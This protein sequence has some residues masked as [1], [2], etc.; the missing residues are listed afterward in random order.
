MKK[1]TSKPCLTISRQCHHHLSWCFV[2]SHGTLSLSLS[3]AVSYCPAPVPLVPIQN[4]FPFQIAIASFICHDR[5]AGQIPR[6]EEENP[7]P[8]HPH[9]RG[10]PRQT[11]A[12]VPVWI[13]G[14]PVISASI[15]SSAS[16]PP[17]Q[18]ILTPSVTEYLALVV[19]HGVAKTSGE[20]EHRLLA[21]PCQEGEYCA[22]DAAHFGR[23]PKRLSFR[24]AVP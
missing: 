18:I 8:V 17:S 6:A 22:E 13:F 9:E 14:S 19:A 12:H 15:L 5:R 2:F 7:M 24:G 1:I 20:N 23:T 16:I 21:H 11:T 10:I 4:R 3:A